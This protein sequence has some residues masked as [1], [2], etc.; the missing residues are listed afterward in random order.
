MTAAA[1]LTAAA[2]ALSACAPAAGGTRLEHAEHVP[3]GTLDAADARTHLDQL[4][5]A[6]PGTLA[7]YVRDCDHGKACVFGR[8]WTDTD[9]DGCDQRSQVL[10]RD[11]ADVERKPGR[12]AVTAGT[13]TDPYTGQTVTSVSKIQ[14]DHVVSLGEMWRTGASSWSTQRRTAAANDLRNLLAVS[15]KNNQAKSDKPAEQ[16]LPHITTGYGCA[17]ARITITVKSAYQ[18][19]ITASEKSAL[20]TALSACR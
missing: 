10:A 13:L 18:L 7:G 15:S 5:V 2:V 9:N 8:P 6:A 17:F 14:I 4:R 16:W 19:T 11:L 3:S 1:V 20:T 12:C